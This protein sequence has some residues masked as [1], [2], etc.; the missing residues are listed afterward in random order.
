MKLL[1]IIPLLLFSMVGTA[2]GEL[3]WYYPKELAHE[4]A[5]PFLIP[6]RAF[7]N[8]QSQWEGQLVLWQG[9]AKN[10]KPDYPQMLN[11]ELA[12]GRSIEVK[13]SRKVKNMQASRENSTVGV[14]GHLRLTSTGKLYLEGRSLIPWSPAGGFKKGTPLIEQWIAYS[15]PQLSLSTQLKIKEAIELEARRES[16]DPLFLTSLIQIESGFDPA[17][18]SVSG[19]LGLGQLMPATAAGLG[20]SPTSIEGNV[21]GCA[22]MIAGLIRRYRSHRDGKALA[23]ASYN[24][25]PSLVARIKRVPPYEQTVNYVYFIGSLYRHLK[26]QQKLVSNDLDADKETY[27]GNK[28]GK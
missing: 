23:L 7:T 9:K 4:Y 19:S 16:I 18:I 27:S 17:A 1:L 10:V 25:G 21:R 8:W 2:R 13:F 24:A 26:L 12:K 11:L 20:V 14:K 28:P 22:K 5:N 3:P 6:E 15:R